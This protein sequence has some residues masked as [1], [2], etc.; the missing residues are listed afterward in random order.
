[1]QFFQAR[2]DA[3]EIF[4]DNISKLF[5]KAIHVLEKSDLCVTVS[6]NANGIV[7]KQNIIKNMI[8]YNYCFWT[9]ETESSL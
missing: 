5:H 8:K 9:L 6:Y 3:K 2:N 7:Q 4:A 1:M